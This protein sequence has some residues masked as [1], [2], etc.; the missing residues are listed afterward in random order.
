MVTRGKRKE[1]ELAD[2]GEHIASYRGT[3]LPNKLAARRVDLVAAVRNDNSVF[4][5][6]GSSR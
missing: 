5:C 4:L 3:V 6:T 1:E 2:T